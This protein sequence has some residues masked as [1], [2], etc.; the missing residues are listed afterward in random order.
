MLE[1]SVRHAWPLIRQRRVQTHESKRNP[2]WPLRLLLLGIPALGPCSDVFSHSSSV[3][4][5]SAVS[6]S[7]K[8]PIPMD[9]L[10]TRCPSGPF[11]PAE[12]QFPSVCCH[13]RASWP[14]PNTEG[15]KGAREGLLLRCAKTQPGTP[16]RRIL[17]RLLA[18]CS[19][20]SRKSSSSSS[21]SLSLSSLS[22]PFFFL[23]VSPPHDEDTPLC[24]SSA[25]P[26][27]V[28]CRVPH[29]TA[30]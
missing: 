9:G 30:T 17:L 15:V 20:F 22:S 26:V 14:P 11:P 18:E 2:G 6:Q 27:P 19:P 25:I 4:A 23:R 12:C 28:Q 29:L 7:V 16:L 21:S 13:L 10:G 1:E 24:S 3:G 8:S 5:M